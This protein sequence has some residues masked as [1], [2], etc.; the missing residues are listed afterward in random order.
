MFWIYLR[1]TYIWMITTGLLWC[2]GPSWLCRVTKTTKHNTCAP[3]SV[4]ELKEEGLVSLCV[5]AAVWMITL[6]YYSGRSLT[7]FIP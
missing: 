4:S 5:R 3:L 2:N 1:L 7:L 6:L